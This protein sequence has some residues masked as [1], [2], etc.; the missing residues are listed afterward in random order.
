M[1]F[2]NSSLRWFE[3]S[4]GGLDCFPHKDAG[5]SR[6][7]IFLEVTANYHVTNDSEMT[8]QKA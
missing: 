8:H 5:Y 1:A 3:I 2:D 6:S 4:G 7:L